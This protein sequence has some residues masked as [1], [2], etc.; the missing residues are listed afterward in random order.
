MAVRSDLVFCELRVEAWKIL[1]QK[2]GDLTLLL[3]EII[4]HHT[5]KR[6]LVQLKKNTVLLSHRTQTTVG[7]PEKTNFPEEFSFKVYIF[8]ASRRPV[9]QS[10][11]SQQVFEMCVSSGFF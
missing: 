5:I 11:V 1:V 6:C 7:S 10:V 3:P 8:L 9:R 4:L 2:F